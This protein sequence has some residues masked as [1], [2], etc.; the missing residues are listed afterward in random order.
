MPIKKLR[1][2]NYNYNFNDVT[3][4]FARWGK[5]LED[6]P[7]Y[8]AVGPEIADIEISTVCSGIG[9]GPCSHCYKS[10]TAVGENM[11]L[12]TFKKVFSKLPKTLTQIAFGIGDIWA[13]KDIYRIMQYCRNNPHNKVVP[14][15][16]TNGYKLKKSDIERLAKLCGAVAVSRYNPPDVCY[17][18]VKDLTDAGMKQVNIH[19]LLAEETY[20]DCFKLIDEAKSDYRLK[21][22]NAIVFLTLKPKGARNNMTTLKSFTKYRELIEYAFS[23]GISIGFDSCSAPM[24]LQAMKDHE[25]YDMYETLS[26]PCESFLFSI[27]INTEGKAYPCSFLEDTKGYKGVDLTEIDDFMKE[28]WYGDEAKLFRDK[29]LNSKCGNCRACPEYDLYEEFKDED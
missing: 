11:S 22:L 12:E 29:V 9:Y 26:E 23:K 18:T 15:V 25:N 28:V 1:S 7:D 14:N 19:M 2:E 10:N 16:T 5:T 20:E 6:D 21:N 17:N 8:S 13:N 27:Y 3:G 4:Q 24:F